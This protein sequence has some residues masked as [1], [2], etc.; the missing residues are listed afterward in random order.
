MLDSKNIIQ[1]V[2]DH[3]A[4][5]TDARISLYELKR[6]YDGDSDTDFKSFISSLFKDYSYEI[7]RQEKV[8]IVH[9]EKTELDHVTFKTKK[10]DFIAIFKNVNKAAEKKIANASIDELREKSKEVNIFFKENIL[11]IQFIEPIIPNHLLQILIK[12]ICT[13]FGVE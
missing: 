11:E 4:R 9:S 13:R 7:L 1:Y 8:L 5:K 2:E 10:E 12:D 3:I 6:I